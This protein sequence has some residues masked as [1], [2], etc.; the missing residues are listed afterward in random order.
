MNESTIDP[1]QWLD[2]YGDSLYRY[3][4]FHC[5]DRQAAEDLVQETFVSALRSLSSYSGKSAFRT[6]LFGILK[7]KILNYY[8]QKSRDASLSDW[9]REENRSVEELFFR[10]GGWRN[11]SWA[12][13]SPNQ[14]LQESEFWLVLHR[15]LQHLPQTMKRIFAL[16]VLEDISKEEICNNLQ[17]TATNVGV[18]LYRARL[19]MRDC[20][21]KNGFESRD[22]KKS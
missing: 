22:K 10:H 16:R 20:L 5:S 17:L 4:L 6:W 8:R 14:A 19:L 2:E 9:E 7:H 13:L 12:P 11:T 21:Q 18:I 1:E 15:C 3:A